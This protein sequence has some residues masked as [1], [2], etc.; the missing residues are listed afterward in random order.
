VRVVLA[1]SA[2]AVIRSSVDVA[3][4]VVAFDDRLKLV[5]TLAAHDEAPTRFGCGIVIVDCPSCQA[6]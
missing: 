6:V 3:L 4:C 2:F 5:A 1:S